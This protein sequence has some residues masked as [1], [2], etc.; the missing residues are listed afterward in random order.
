[1]YCK[2]R[3]SGVRFQ[4]RKAKNRLYAC[5]CIAGYV[6]S[7]PRSVIF[8]CE[9]IQAAKMTR[10]CEGVRT[11]GVFTRADE[12]GGQR[13]GSEEHS[14]VD[15]RYMVASLVT[16]SQS[17]HLHAFDRF[18]SLLFLQARGLFDLSDP[19]LCRSIENNGVHAS[20]YCHPGCLSK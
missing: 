18:R 7:L 13:C 17:G 5:R 9:F 10:W 19:V 20:M 6:T 11:R 8:L 16:L 2:R 15:F 1:M 12:A 3:K 14:D 4:D